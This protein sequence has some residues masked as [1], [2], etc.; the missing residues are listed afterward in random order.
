[1]QISGN[2]VLGITEIRYCPWCG[3]KIEVVKVK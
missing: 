1:M 3:E 2:C